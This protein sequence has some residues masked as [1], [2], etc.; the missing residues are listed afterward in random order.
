MAHPDIHPCP[1]CGRYNLEDTECTTCG[2]E[3]EFCAASNPECD[4]EEGC[5]STDEPAAP[6]SPDCSHTRCPC[7][8]DRHR[9]EK[10]GDEADQ[11]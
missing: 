5:G 6:R 3:H 9:E 11:S 10:I 2:C 8:K 1:R 7:H 4:W